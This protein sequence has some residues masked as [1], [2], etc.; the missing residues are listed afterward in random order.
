V[1]AITLALVGVSCQQVANNPSPSITSL[2]PATATAG[3]TGFLMTVI[4]SGFSPQ[5]V[6]SFN[7]VRRTDT[8]FL[9]GTQITTMIQPSDIANAGT[10]TVQVSAPPPGGGTSGTLPFVIN[11]GVSGVPQLTSISPS[12]T[13]AGGTGLTLTV[14]GTGFNT[15]S[16]V[17]LNSGNRTTAFVN[18]GELQAQVLSTDLV[19][20]GTFAVGV[21][22][23]PP[24]GGASNTLTLT[25]TNPPPVIGGIVPATFAAQAVG[26]AGSTLSVLGSGFD[27]VS[28]VNFNSSPRTTTFATQDAITAPLLSNDLI[29]A[30]TFPITVVNPTPGGG[31][32]NPF[33]FSVIASTAGMGL[34]QQIDVSSSGLQANAGTTD[35]TGSGPAVSSIGQ[36]ILFAS[37][38]TNLSITDTNNVP[39]V[40]FQNNCIGNT[41]L[42]CTPSTIIGS[43]SGFGSLSNG[44]SSQPTEDSSGRFIAFVSTATNLIPGNNRFTGIPQVYW[45]DTC[46]GVTIA[47]TPFTILVSVA[48]DGV[49]PGNAASAQPSLSSDGRYVAYSSAASNLQ[50]AN[51]SGLAQIFVF[52]TCSGQ[53]TCSTSTTLI[54]VAPDGVTPGNAASTQPSLGNLA[55]YVAFTSPATNLISS[56]LNGIQQVFQR[57]TCIGA[58]GCI[59]LTILASTPDGTTAGNGISFQPSMGIDGRIVSFASTATNLVSTVTSGI[60][61]VFLRD[62]CTGATGCTASTSLVSVAT[63]G[64]SAGNAASEHPSVDS[65]GQYV[66]FASFASNLVGVDTNNLEDVFVRNTCATATGCTAGTVLAS[67]SAANGGVGVQGNG[68]SLSPAISADHTTVAFLSFA[69]NLVPQG[70]ADQSNVFLASTTF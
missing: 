23:P 18:N 34:P 14:I 58:T 48:S 22:N 66:A 43:V 15:T 52:D 42:L 31:T 37:P 27:S 38:A 17:T 63:D 56:G 21:T 69:T 53:T 29:T 39:D 51:S 7:G 50:A 6:I 12:S 28:Q 60:Q 16:V 44:A 64:L 54:S 10:I 36:Y 26:N 35:T 70:T 55:S 25:V 47:C 24:G 49:T 61:Q 46:T 4:G 8:M 68:D 30:G 57:T 3:G 32:S 11:P 45:R 20:A 2:S 1:A 19:T 9:S 13:F 40:F 59:P 65:T 41:T 5:A 62:T 67:I 33:G